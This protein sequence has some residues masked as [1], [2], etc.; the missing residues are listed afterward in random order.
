[1]W[2]W[3]WDVLKAPGPGPPQ[4]EPPDYSPTRLDFQVSVTHSLNMQV[5]LENA[6]L[7]SQTEEYT[8]EDSSDVRT[9]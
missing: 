9:Q 5:P 4:A 6:P 8:A 2:V 3:R 7:H 1:M